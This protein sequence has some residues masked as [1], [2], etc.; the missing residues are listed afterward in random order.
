VPGLN[1]ACW[2]I[3]IAEKLV[4]KLY[5][6]VGL[7]FV[8][9]FVYLNGSMAEVIFR[10]KQN[11]IYTVNREEQMYYIAVYRLDGYIQMFPDDKVKEMLDGDDSEKAD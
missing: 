10:D 6:P 4:K 1:G 8:N 11:R 7:E 2:M 5:D 3:E 9:I